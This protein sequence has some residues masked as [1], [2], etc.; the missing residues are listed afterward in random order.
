M[1]MLVRFLSCLLLFSFASLASAES[2]DEALRSYESGDYD[3]AAALLIPLAEKG[4]ASAQHR[5]SVMHF[6]GRGVPEDENI[7]MKWAKEA[8]DQ[9]NV[10]AMYFIG[11]MYVFGDEIPKSVEDPDLEAAKWIFDAAS[12]GHADAE[13]ALGL[14]FLAGKGVELDR[15][16]A[17]KWIERA[18]EHGHATARSFLSGGDHSKP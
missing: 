1:P 4:E 14:L 15:F 10:D 13:Y 17:M 6:Y 5:L 9:G 12:R 8:A 3:R 2:L 11:T 18:A 7:A 16:E